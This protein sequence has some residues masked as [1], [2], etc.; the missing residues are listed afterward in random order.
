[1]NFQYI[2]VDLCD[3]VFYNSVFCNKENKILFIIV[4]FEIVCVLILCL[5][6]NEIKKIHKN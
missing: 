5:N 3:N 4:F 1:M 2:M 6:K